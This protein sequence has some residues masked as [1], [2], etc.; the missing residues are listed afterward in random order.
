[1]WNH[2]LYGYG[3]PDIDWGPIFVSIITGLVSGFLV[4]FFYNIKERK[5]AK[6]D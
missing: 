2:I 5:Y 4:S 1:M 3:L 6:T